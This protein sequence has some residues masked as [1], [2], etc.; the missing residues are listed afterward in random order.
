MIENYFLL[1]IGTTSSLLLDLL[2]TIAFSLFFTYGI[3]EIRTSL[4]YNN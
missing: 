2:R 3:N 4:F 1:W